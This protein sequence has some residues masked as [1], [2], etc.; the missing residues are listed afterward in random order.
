MAEG[1][2]TARVI[3]DT[4]KNLRRTLRQFLVYIHVKKIYGNLINVDCF[5][6]VNLQNIIS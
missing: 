1:Q 3:S 6:I 5:I 2:K 4:L